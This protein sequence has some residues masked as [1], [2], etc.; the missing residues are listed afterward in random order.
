MRHFGEATARPAPR[1]AL[2]TT[3][4][5]LLLSRKARLELEIKNRHQVARETGTPARVAMLSATLRAT[6]ARLAT[7]HKQAADG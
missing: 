1:P 7:Q 4:R 2:V 5:D 3:M 6:K